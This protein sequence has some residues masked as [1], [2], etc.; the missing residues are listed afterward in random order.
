MTQRQYLKALATLGLTPAGQLTA[1]TIGLTIRQLQRIA[2]GE[3]AV[4]G[5]VA[6]LLELMIALNVDPAAI[7]TSD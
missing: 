3:N 6:R 5:P 2:A 1:K 7:V 4:P